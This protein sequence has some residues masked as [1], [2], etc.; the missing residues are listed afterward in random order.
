MSALFWLGM[1]IGCG[2]GIWLLVVAFNAGF[3]WG[4]LTLIV[5]FVGLV[6][7]ITH[8]HDAKKPFLLNLVAGALVWIAIW[9]QP[10]LL[11]TFR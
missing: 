8:W 4:L 2:A 3:W 9:R 5:P 1:I 7:I 6:F 10:A 11:D